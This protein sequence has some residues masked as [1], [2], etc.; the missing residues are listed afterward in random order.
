MA[1]L[2]TL[3]R[4]ALI[5]VIIATWARQSRVDWWVLDLLMVPLLGWAIFMDALDGWVARRRQE[6][7]EAGALF[8][9][10]GDRIVELVL[11][12]FFAIRRDAD[13]IPF[14]A[15]WV[16]LVIV[17]RTV[18]T[19][20]V[21]SVAFRDGRTP[22]GDKTLQEASWA[23]SLTSS[24]WSRALYGILKAVTFC[25]LGVSFA[26]DRFRDALVAYEAWRVLTD[27]LVM[28]TVLMAILRGFPVLWEGRRY[29]AADGTKTPSEGSGPA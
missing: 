17:A 26:W 24:R 15:Y 29:L 3:L 21:R 11:W 12:I 6:A 18:L 20:L 22:F 1:N 16:P 14:V 19:D 28:A 27:V 10:A 13:G 2:L 25:A 7:S 23:R 4:V 5:F 8:D 9:I